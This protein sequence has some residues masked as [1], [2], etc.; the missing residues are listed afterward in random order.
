MSRYRKLIAA[1][2]GMLMLVVNRFT[3]GLF[4]GFDPFIVDT[5]I[6]VG[7]MAGVYWLPNS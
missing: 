1:G 2:V 4:T 7:T 3:D 5:I 6:E